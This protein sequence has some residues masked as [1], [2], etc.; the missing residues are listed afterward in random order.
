MRNEDFI[1]QRNKISERMS[2]I[3]QKIIVMSGKGGVGK[4]TFSANLAIAFAVKGYENKVGILDA[5]IHGYSIP[6]MF[7]MISQRMYQADDG[8]LPAEGPLGIK[9]ASV[10]F[11]IQDED[12]PI[13]WRGPL[14]AQLIR[15]FLSDI[16]WGELEFLIVDLPPGTGDE[17]LS[18]AQDLPNPDGVVIVTIPSEVSEKVVRRSVG[19]AKALNLPIIGVVENMSGFICPYCG[20]KVDIFGSGGGE[21]IAKDL[22]IPFLGKIPLDVKINESGDKGLPFIVEKRDSEITKVFLEIT[23]KIESF[24]KGR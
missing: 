12:S 4:S 24:L 9:V 6:K 20:A 2:K 7:N 19:F 8:I 10:G 15:Q 14:K 22:K 18:I 3:K 16:V 1:L 11:M 21:R 13:I 23:D 5:D 17:P